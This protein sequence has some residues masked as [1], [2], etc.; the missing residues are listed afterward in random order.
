MFVRCLGVKLDC[1][2]LQVM[3]ALCFLGC[4]E[5]S[6]GPTFFH[7]EH[8]KVF[9]N[10]FSF[11]AAMSSCEKGSQWQIAL[12]V[13]NSISAGSDLLI[14][15]KSKGVLRGSGYLVTGCM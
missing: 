1:N 6:S 2:C 3:E 7:V 15:K 4:L 8:S 9:P 13:L 10:N 5:T 12:Q 11:N 14:E